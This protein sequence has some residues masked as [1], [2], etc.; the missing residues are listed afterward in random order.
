[1]Y[2]ARRLIVFGWSLLGVAFSFGQTISDPGFE[3]V[4]GYSFLTGPTTAGPWSVDRGCVGIVNA[5]FGSPH[6]GRQVLVVPMTSTASVCVVSQELTGFVPGH[7]YRL[8]FFTSIYRNPPFTNKVVGNVR[9]GSASLDLIYPAD[10]N[11]GA[12]GGE[13]PWLTRQFDFA[14]AAHTLRLHIT[15]SH[16]G[17]GGF[18]AFDDFALQPLT[19]QLTDARKK[20]ATTIDKAREPVTL[21]PV[22]VTVTPDPERLGIFLAVELCWLSL[23][24]RNYQI[25][26][27]S[28]AAST[29][30]TNFGEP[31]AGDGTLKCVFD[32]TRYQSTRFYRVVALSER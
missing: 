27:A 8:S 9:L 11:F 10:P 14:A 5:G 18:M 1:M 25:Q 20:T 17:H 2:S 13:S 23:T 26:W 31:V 28:S 19:R 24:N 6:S 32:S 22:E 7:R 3:M 15:A 12:L 21:I 30:W 4:S 16:E 29:N